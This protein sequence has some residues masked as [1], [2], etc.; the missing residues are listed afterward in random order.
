MSNIYVYCMYV[1]QGS[2]FKLCR[3]CAFSTKAM[4]RIRTT[5]ENRCALLGARLL[6]LRRPWRHTPRSPGLQGSVT[7]Y[8]PLLLSVLPHWV[9]RLAGWTTCTKFRTP[10]LIW[11]RKCTV[12]PAGLEL[13]DASGRT[14][15]S[16]GPRGPVGTNRS[17]LTADRHV[18]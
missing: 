6:R 5:M 7:P 12:R 14:K 1:W 8:N 9:K 10:Y 18:F 13:W 17:E 2:F 11:R 15:R 3:Q 4:H 16:Q